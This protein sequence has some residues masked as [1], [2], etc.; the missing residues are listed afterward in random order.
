MVADGGAGG[1][2]RDVLN[3]GA[4]YVYPPGGPGGEYTATLT[5]IPAGTTLSIFPGGSGPG[6]GGGSGGGVDLIPD[7][8]GWG[9]GASTVAIT[10]FSVARLLVVAGGGGGTANNGGNPNPDLA[11]GAGGGSGYADG[12]AGEDGGSPGGGGGGGTT[13]KG[14]IGGTESGCFYQGAAG[15]QLQGG[16]SAS[17]STPHLGDCDGGGGGGSGY[18]GGGGGGNGGGGGGSGFPAASTVTDGITITPDTADTSTN[19]GN[20]VVTISYAAAAPTGPIVSGY[21]AALCAADSGDS[22]VNDTPVTIATCDPAPAR[23]GP[24]PGQA[25]C[26]STANAWTST[27]TKKPTR[28]PSNCRPAP[29][30]PTSNGTPPPPGHLSTRYPANASTTPDSAPPPA[31]SSSIYTCNGGANQQWKLP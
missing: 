6:S 15:G 17:D 7:Q 13:T 26:R 22:A 10:P 25:P 8:S 12:L 31:P 23:T 18:F 1:A 29:P 5:G 14:G 27:A 11:G 2:A 21:R 4:E 28:P 30:A 16:N 9:G 3:S 20:G 24:S 19:T